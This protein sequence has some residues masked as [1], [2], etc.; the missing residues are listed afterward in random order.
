MLMPSTSIS[1]KIFLAP[2]PRSVVEIFQPSDLDRL[3]A[4][5]DLAIYEHPIIAEE[6]FE[7]AATSADIIIGQVDLPE[8]RLIRI[9]KL[10][11]I[12]NVEGNLQPNV[13]YQYCF[14]HGIRVLTISPVFAEPV[15]ELGLGLAIDL[16]RGITRSDEDFR[17]GA[18]EY[19]LT[20]NREALSLFNQQVG[21]VGFG[22]LARALLP[23][24]VPF[25]CTVRVYD[26]WLPQELL[27]QVGCEACSLEDVLRLSRVIFILASATAENEGFIGAAQ[28]SLMPPGA[29]LVLLS[30][31]AVVDFDA[32]IQ[33]IQSRRIRVATD[34]FPEEPLPIDHAARRTENLLLSAHKAGALEHTLRRIGTIVVADCEMICRGLPPALCKSAQPETVCLFRSAPVARS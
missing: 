32:M 25:R 22:D 8:S 34:V 21:F 6:V 9:P 3:R 12:F 17:R 18:E 2:A 33:A 1:Q 4:L 20:A 31:A 11:A 23:L 10:K 19:G 26:P 7:E 29:A 5:G 15:A 30:R 14:R 16:L 13:D 24:L 27:T 28:F